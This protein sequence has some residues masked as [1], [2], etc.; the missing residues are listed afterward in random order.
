L[1]SSGRCTGILQY[2]YAPGRWGMQEVEGEHP[3]HWFFIV[4]VPPAS[5]AHDQH[6]VEAISAKCYCAPPQGMK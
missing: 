1:R 5:P 6:I 2:T 3:T 4:G